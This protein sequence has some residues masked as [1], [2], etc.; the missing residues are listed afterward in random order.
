M[1][2]KWQSSERRY[3]SEGSMALLGS[4]GNTETIAAIN[5]GE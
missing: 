2:D 4:S 5:R 1:H 3:L